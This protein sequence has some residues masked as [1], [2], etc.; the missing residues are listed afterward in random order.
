MIFSLV[1][2]VSTNIPNVQAK[3]SIIEMKIPTSITYPNVTDFEN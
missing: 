2:D 3:G 1:Q